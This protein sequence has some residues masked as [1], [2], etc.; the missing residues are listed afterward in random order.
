MHLKHGE[1]EITIFQAEGN[2]E[3]ALVGRRIGIP[4]EA[5]TQL[6]MDQRLPLYQMAGPHE[7]AI[8]Q[9]QSW[10]DGFEWAADEF[11]PG[12]L[13]WE[14]TEQ[15]RRSTSHSLSDDDRRGVRAF[16][17]TSMNDLNPRSLMHALGFTGPD[18]S[19]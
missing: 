9:R 3:K 17:M 11:G 12:D 7:L 8:L 6:P 5:W 13:I 4:G 14:F 16:T 10:Y 15:L 2:L 19:A 18:D 1:T